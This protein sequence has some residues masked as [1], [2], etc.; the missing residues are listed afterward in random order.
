MDDA[1]HVAL[2]EKGVPSPGGVW[3]DFGSG[4]GA[5]TLALADLIGQSAV[6]YS[7][8]KNRTALQQQKSIVQSRFPDLT[9]QYLHNDFTRPID[10]PP[11]DGLIMA[12]AL[13]FVRNKDQVVKAIH[14]YLKPEGRLVL[15]EYNVDRGNIWVP[16]PLSFQTWQRLASQNGFR[17]TLLLATRQ[18]SF[19]EEFYSALSIK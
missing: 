13:H 6:L 8:D 7:V 4:Q 10:L 3:A 9:I 2:L 17:T 5:F 14:G 11:L 18:S 19:L 16:H 12:N 15:V 1:D